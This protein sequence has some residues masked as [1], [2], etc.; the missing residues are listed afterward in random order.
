MNVSVHRRPRW[1]AAAVI[2]AVAAVLAI[3]A[4]LRGASD[5]ARG[6]DA[7]DMLGVSPF[8]LLAASVDDDFPQPPPRWAFEFPADHRAH[9]AYR[10]EWWY[11]SGTL[12]DASGADVPMLGVQWLLM[13]IALRSEA[14]ASGQTG[15]ER[16]TIGIGAEAETE[17]AELEPVEGESAELE[18]VEGEST[19]LNA[20]ELESAAPA[21]AWS[22]SQIYAGLFSI[23]APTGTGLR[24]DGK[25]SRGALGLAGAT[26]PPVRVW[27]ENWQL[28]ELEPDAGR[29]ADAPGF[30]LHL[31][32][33]GLELDLELR[34]MKRPITASDVA[35]GSGARAAPF[36]FYVQPRLRARGT[37]VADGRRFDVDGVFALEHA[38]GE[39]PLPGGPVGNDRFSLHLDDGSEL[40]LVR[41]HRRRAGDERTATTTALLIDPQGSAVPLADDDVTLEPM[42][43]WTSPRTGTRYPLRWSLRVPGRD[44]ETTL[45][46]IEADH[47]GETWL[48]FWA[49]PVRIDGTAAGSG[50]VQLNGYAEP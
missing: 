47:E 11:L 25:L 18:P 22:T 45:T 15:A 46:P 26:A 27:I 35:G 48:Q 5:P 1:I 23:S 24:T 49:G 14:G 10:T 38:W 19:E 3:A 31:G 42:D 13:R 28:V 37:L 21:S 39:L 34:D 7:A 4:S 50:F 9:D 20:A 41:T 32:T 40:I 30:A 16:A 29:T 12:N 8:A 43:Y 44:I 17:S 2:A 36:Q 6:R 33:D